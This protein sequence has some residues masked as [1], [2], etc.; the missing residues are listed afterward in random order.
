[1]ERCLVCWNPGVWP[2]TT[3]CNLKPKHKGDHK[4]HYGRIL[5]NIPGQEEQ[6]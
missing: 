4:D 1:M 5:T 3:R 2:Y 6:A